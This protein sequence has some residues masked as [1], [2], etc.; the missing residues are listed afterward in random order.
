MAFG[1]FIHRTDS[2]YDDVPSVQYQFP[3]QY[4]TRAQ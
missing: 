4:L 1:V 3:N 2:I